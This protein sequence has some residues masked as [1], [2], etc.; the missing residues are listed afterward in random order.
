[1]AQTTLIQILQD[2]G[3][4]RL[5]TLRIVAVSFHCFQF[6]LGSFTYDLAFQG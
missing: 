5:E 1:M 4:G 3:K 2:L 6:H